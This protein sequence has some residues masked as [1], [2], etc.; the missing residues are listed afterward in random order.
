[1]E[2]FDTSD[3]ELSPPSL[4]AWDTSE[5]EPWS[6]SE[7][8]SDPKAKPK[9]CKAKLKDCKPKLKP[10]KGTRASR[11]DKP[12]TQP[13]HPGANASKRGKKNSQ[14]TE[15]SSESQTKRAKSDEQESKPKSKPK[16]SSLRG[17]V[18]W[19]L[20]Q[21]PS[22]W[23]KGLDNKT[24][25]ISSLFSGMGTEMMAMEALRDTLEVDS[26]IRIKASHTFVCE[27]DRRK[28][29]FLK[30]HYG[31]NCDWFFA[32]VAELSKPWAMDDKSGEAV[33][34]PSGQAVMV[35]GFSCKDLS[36]L[37]GKPKSE[38]GPAGTSAET[39]QGALRY[40]EALGF[41]ERPE[42]IIVENA[43]APAADLEPW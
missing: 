19:A 26:N 29:Q 11:A 35:F 42:L 32:D 24:I 3:V 31:R 22:T 41:E 9:D 33:K 18:R 10:C 30:R 43:G 5:E 20:Q 17:F 40:L 1:M 15:A 21:L 6:A 38:R 8:V 39:L 12:Q 4:D 37:S 27:K 36:G 28:L 2:D 16:D 34:R 14:N 23:L 25:S 13:S 7:C